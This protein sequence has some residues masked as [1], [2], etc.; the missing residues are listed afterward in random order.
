MPR[1]TLD[2]GDRAL[3]RAK[4]FCHIATVR[5]DGTIL[6]V[7]VWVDTDG[8][9]II[10]NSSEGRAWPENLRRAGHATCTVSD[11]SDPYHYMSATVRIA[12]DTHEGADDDI[13]RL[14]K[15]YMDVDSY[16]FRQEGEQRVI[17]R[18]EPERVFVQGG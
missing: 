9:H 13:D 10:V 2:D 4:N 7:P 15:K 5:E 16:P 18:I 3:L 6:N 14:A 11:S 8:E 12:E 1:T 17:F